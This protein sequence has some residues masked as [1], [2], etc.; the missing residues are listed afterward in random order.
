MSLRTCGSCTAC[1]DGWLKIKIDGQE[2]RQGKPCPHSSGTGCRIYENRPQHPCVEFVCGWISPDSAM[3]DWMKPD[4]AKLIVLHGFGNWRGLKVDLAVPVG[5]IIPQRSLTWLRN[6][7]SL[8]NR[9]LIW[10][11]NL[12]AN[13]K[14]TGQ[15]SVHGFGPPEFQQ[16]VRESFV[17]HEGDAM[18]IL[19]TMSAAP[20]LPPARP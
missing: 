5:R 19:G 3:P 12:R 15:Q 2:V 6:Y 18:R 10:T 14:F 16:E 11:E 8:N 13:G 9:P 7:A 1:C 20:A 4:I 17:K